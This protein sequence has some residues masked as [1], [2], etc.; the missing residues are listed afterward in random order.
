MTCLDAAN[1]FYSDG[2]LGPFGRM[3]NLTQGGW[4]RVAIDE[5]NVF[6]G[7]R[8][9]VLEGDVQTVPRAELRAIPSILTHVAVDAKDMV[10]L[11]ASY[12]LGFSDNP[13][14]KARPDNGDM[15]MEC[16]KL[17]LTKRIRIEVVKIPR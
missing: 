16:W 10:R 9:G 3:A 12:L 17:I 6:I 8:W 13:E 1:E 14:T 4:G 11:D 5:A 2:T 15:R 7:G